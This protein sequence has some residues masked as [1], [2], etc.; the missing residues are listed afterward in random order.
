MKEAP[1]E[2]PMHLDKAETLRA[3]DD[4]CLM[5]DVF[6]SKCSGKQGV[7]GSDAQDYPR[8]E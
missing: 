2:V 5:D 4:M 7:H 8:T 1:K 3:L 6:F